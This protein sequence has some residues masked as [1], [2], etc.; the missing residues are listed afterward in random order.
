MEVFSFLRVSCS[1]SLAVHL[2]SCFLPH[3]CT[4]F[5]PPNMSKSCLMCHDKA[6]HEIDSPSFSRNG[7]EGEER[8]TCSEVHIWVKCTVLSSPSHI[9]NVFPSHVTHSFLLLLLL[10]HLPSFF[11]SP[12]VADAYNSLSINEFRPSIPTSSLTHPLPH[13]WLAF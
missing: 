9:F 2:I 10:C 13:V 7:V 12:S 1:C 5:S 8:E 6:C 11:W 3:T 4:L